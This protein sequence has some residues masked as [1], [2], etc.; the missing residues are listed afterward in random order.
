MT[1]DPNALIGHPV[2][3]YMV[4]RL[5][6]EGGYAWVFEARHP[7]DDVPVALKVLRPR[8][9]ADRELERR[10]RNEYEVASRLRHPNIIRIL[11]IG[12]AGEITYF[13][14]DRAPDT[15]ADRLDR[16]GPLPETGLVDLA[17]GIAAALACA[18]EAGIIHRDVKVGNI[19]LTKG[20]RPVLTDFGIARALASYASATGV[21]MTIG[22]PHYIAPEQAQGRPLDGRTD[23]YALGVTLYKAATGSLP[24][25]STDWYDLARMHVEEAPETPRRR[26][27]DL[28]PRL[29]RMILKLMAKHPDERYSTAEELVSELD[30]GAR[31]APFAGEPHRTARAAGDRRLRRDVSI[32]AIMVLVVAAIL[33][34]LL[35]G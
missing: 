1:L 29:E 23:L 22:T 21:D 16:D 13:A 24:F 28:S 11:D 33:V 3:P 26:R 35:S 25:R 34:A 32:A 7:Q 27:P 6:G 30:G 14:M 12:R 20:G 18:H 8:F 4:L 19:L 15:L 2:G 10:F 31:R 9:A 5:I 17:K